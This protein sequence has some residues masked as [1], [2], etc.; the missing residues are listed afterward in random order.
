MTCDGI[1]KGEHDIADLISFCLLRTPYL[2]LPPLTVLRTGG[3]E[4]GGY[5]ELPKLEIGSIIA[6]DPELFGAHK[7]PI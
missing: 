5:M 4:P 3:A 6:S 1:S 2:R 7:W